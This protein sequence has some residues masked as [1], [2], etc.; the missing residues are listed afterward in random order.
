MLLCKCSKAAAAALKSTASWEKPHFVLWTSGEKTRAAHIFDAHNYCMSRLQSAIGYSMCGGSTVRGAR[1]HTYSGAHC[2]FQSDKLIRIDRWNIAIRCELWAHGSC[3]CVVGFRHRLIRNSIRK[4]HFITQ[5]WT[6]SVVWLNQN[7]R[8]EMIMK[9]TSNDDDDEIQLIN[10]TT[11]NTLYH[12]THTHTYTDLY[13][14]WS[15]KKVNLQL[16][17]ETNDFYLSSRAY[18][19]F[20]FYISCFTFS[21]TLECMWKLVFVDAWPDYQLNSIQCQW[22]PNPKKLIYFAMLIHFES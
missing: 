12:T 21:W 17:I 13:R 11:N 2:E 19:Q 10:G 8:S 1:H 14:K 3:I 4:L 22:R 16:G 5:A 9:T 20:E 15:E 18:C 6:V 7:E